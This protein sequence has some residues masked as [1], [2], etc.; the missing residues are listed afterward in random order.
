MVIVGL[1]TVNNSLIMLA[2]PL[3]SYLVLAIL[4]APGEQILKAQ[5]FLSTDRISEGVDVTIRI[6]VENV[7][8]Q[9]NELHL[10]E[11]TAND[12]QN[13]EGD[14]SRVVELK[15]GEALNYSYTFQGWRGNYEFEGLRARVTD[16]FGLFKV[17]EH[18]PAPGKILVFPPG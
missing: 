11:L 2:L 8:A 1:I 14:V 15:P 6:Q 13:L 10:S 5:R 4:F 16:P 9:S 7:G 3:I 18:L 12:F 17:E